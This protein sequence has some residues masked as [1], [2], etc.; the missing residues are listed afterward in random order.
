[1]EEKKTS[2][3]DRQ[4]NFNF[5]IIIFHFSSGQKDQPDFTYSELKRTEPENTTMDGGPELYNISQLV[6]RPDRQKK[7]RRDN[8][9]RKYVAVAK[10]D[11]SLNG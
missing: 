9:A 5:E 11:N 8:C 7:K 4:L 3:Q 6:S 2:K 1:M 10:R